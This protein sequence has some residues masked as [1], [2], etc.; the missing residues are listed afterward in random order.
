M[1]VIASLLASGLL[2]A[3]TQNLGVKADTAYAWYLPPVGS[4]I[5]LHRSLQLP[6]GHTRVF[7]QRGEVVAKQAFDR[8]QPSCS[9]EIRS[10]AETPRQIDPETF[11][12]TRVQRTT[13]EVVERDEPIMLAAWNFV[14]IDDGPPMVTRGVHLWISSDL[15]PDVMRLTCHGAFDD[16]PEALPPSI[17]EMRGALGSYASLRLSGAGS[18]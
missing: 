2:T 13:E 17:D 9:F 8:Y 5:E 11:L 3:C 6:G 18:P 4:T 7:L 10:L 15:Q 12:I 1:K 14:G 16:P